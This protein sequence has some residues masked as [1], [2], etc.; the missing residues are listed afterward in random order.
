MR[1]HC[2]LFELKFQGFSFFFC[3]VPR[4]TL[5]AGTAKDQTAEL[6]KKQLQSFGDTRWVQSHQLLQAK[7]PESLWKFVSGCLLTSFLNIPIKNY[8]WPSIG[9]LSMSHLSTEKEL[10]SLGCIGDKTTQLYGDFACFRG[11]LE[12]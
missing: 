9:E 2:P 5:L 7:T 3:R 8:F 10:D 6:V 12:A 1:N 11:S 4:V